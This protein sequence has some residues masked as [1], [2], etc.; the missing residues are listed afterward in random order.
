MERK[1]LCIYAILQICMMHFLVTRFI[2]VGFKAIS[3]EIKNQRGLLL[4]NLLDQLK[5]SLNLSSCLKVVAY[6]R[7][8]NVFSEA[9]LRIKFLLARNA[10]FETTLA[11]I[12]N[13]NAYQHI[14]KTMELSRVHL[15][16]IITQYRAVFPDEDPMYVLSGRGGD[17]IHL[18]S[19]FNCWVAEKIDQFFNALK[20]DLATGVEGRLDSV[21]AQCMH[22]GLSLGRVGADFRPL[23]VSV[24][25][26]Y[27]QLTLVHSLEPA[28]NQ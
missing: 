14:T 20:T 4:E 23:T 12:P 24:F 9:E 10:W 3:A 17:T 18:Q 6:L 7:R 21:L 28:T 25:E 13:D 16:D 2:L 1:A 19:I 15:F 22:F 27:V 11:A 8:L 5:T 26:K